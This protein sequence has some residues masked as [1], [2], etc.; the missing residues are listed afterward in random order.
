MDPV[1][2]PQLPSSVRGSFCVRVRVCVHHHGQLYTLLVFRTRKG[3][4]LCS[5]SG[6]SVGDRDELWS[7]ALALGLRQAFLHDLRLRMAMLLHLGN[8][9]HN[10]INHTSLG[11][12][13]LFFG[14]LFF[15]FLIC[16]C[17]YAQAASDG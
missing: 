15:L 2:N 10:I 11:F 17:V 3:Y 12:L 16:D 6:P 8:I 4:I 7:A 5:G 13:F 14:F 1:E 9:L